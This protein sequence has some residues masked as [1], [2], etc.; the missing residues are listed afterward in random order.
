[1]IL[2]IND[3]DITKALLTFVK[4]MNKKEFDRFNKIYADYQ[5]KGQQISH[6]K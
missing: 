3:S 4:G 1:M 5:Y 2:T 6:Q